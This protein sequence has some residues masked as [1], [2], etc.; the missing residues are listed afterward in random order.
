MLGIF[1]PLHNS[2]SRRYR[3]SREGFALKQIWFSLAF[4]QS[5]Q[6][7]SLLLSLRVFEPI[8]YRPGF[9]SNFHQDKRSR[10]Y[11]QLWSPPFY[12]YDLLSLH[13]LTFL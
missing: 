1:D 4:L 9:H 13:P 8:H 12:R 2:R 3:F 6:F 10:H 11:L 5:I 7:F